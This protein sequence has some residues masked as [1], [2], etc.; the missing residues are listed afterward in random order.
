MCYYRT[1]LA[2]GYIYSLS[3]RQGSEFQLYFI[4]S[5]L[6]RI[7][8]SL[9]KWRKFFISTIHLWFLKK[10]DLSS[11]LQLNLP[12]TSLRETELEIPYFLHPQYFYERNKHIF[13]S[14]GTTLLH[15]FQKHHLVVKPS[16]QM[17]TAREGRA[18]CRGMH[19]CR[20]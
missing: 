4:L 16:Q 1:L 17:A 20:V 14:R 3:K 12:N 6:F 5:F 11:M 7:A 8:E 9:K 13:P 10:T 18:G 15:K 2:A 19:S